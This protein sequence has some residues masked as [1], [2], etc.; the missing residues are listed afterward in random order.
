MANCSRLVTH[1]CR[2]ANDQIETLAQTQ[3]L[4]SLNVT[5]QIT[6]IGRWQ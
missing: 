1:W 5:Q 6:C 2:V 4:Y 3:S